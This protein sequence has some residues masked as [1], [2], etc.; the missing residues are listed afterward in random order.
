MRFT[1]SLFPTPE[2]APTIGLVDDTGEFNPVRESGRRDAAQAVRYYRESLDLP[3]TREVYRVLF[4][5]KSPLEAVNELMLREPK[6]D[7]E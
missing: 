3:I 1:S 2:N 7:R 4:E 5:D 6:S